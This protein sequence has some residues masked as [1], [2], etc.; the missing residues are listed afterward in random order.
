MLRQQKEVGPQ[1][2][3]LS[4]PNS[5]SP[6]P[7][8]IFPFRRPSRAPSPFIVRMRMF[9]SWSALRRSPPTAVCIP[10]RIVMDGRESDDPSRKSSLVPQPRKLISYLQPI[11]CRPSVCPPFRAASR[12]VREVPILVC[13]PSNGVPF[14]P[15]PS[16]SLRSLAAL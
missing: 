3:A 10:L 4:T 5:A 8:R 9:A 14:L 13:E 6:T 11:S 16:L 15:S 1:G 2:V 12:R 7:H